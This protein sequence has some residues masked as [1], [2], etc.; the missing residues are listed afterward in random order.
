MIP[1]IPE[2]NHVNEDR[3][4]YIDGPHF[5]KMDSNFG[6]GRHEADALA[7]LEDAPYV[8][9]FVSSWSIEGFHCL[10]MTVKSGDTLENLKAHLT[11]VEK[12]HVILC[13]LE[14]AADLLRRNVIHGDLNE[15]NVL[16]DRKTREVSVIDWET[17]TF[18]ESMAD[19]YGPQWGL[20]DLLGRLK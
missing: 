2:T 6:R 3:K 18:G 5:I 17:A 13:L 14:I 8:P 1:F 7:L 20:I 15:S 4:Y 16:F 11:P 10:R 19:I 9:K 12:R